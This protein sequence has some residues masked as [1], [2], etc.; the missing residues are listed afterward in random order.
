VNLYSVVVDASYPYQAN[1]KFIT[2]LKVIDPSCH[3]KGDEA[4]A[5]FKHSLVIV[6]AKRL[7]D[8][9]VVR[10]VGDI[11][12]VHR[13]NTREHKGTRQFHVNVNFNASWVLWPSC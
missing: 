13:A 2:T 5:R 9:P 3:T 11:M 7:E 4:T 6:Y 1:G 8:C 12:R 10:K